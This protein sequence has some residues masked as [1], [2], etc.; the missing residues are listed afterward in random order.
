MTLTTTTTHSVPVAPTTGA[1]RPLGLDEVTHHRRVLGPAP[2]GER[3]ARPSRTSAD[4]SSAR[5]GSATSTSRHPDACPRGAAGASSRTPRSTSTSRPMAWEIGRRGGA[6]E[7]TDE[8]E[9]RFH[10]VVARVAAA[11]EPDGYL[12]TQFGRPGQQPRWS[13]LEWGHELYCLG[14]LFQATVARVRTRPDAD[15]GLV[16]V[17][18]RAADLVCEVFGEG[19]IERICGH[20]EVE[21]GLAELGRAL[22]RAALPG[23]GATLRRAPRPRHAARHRVGSLVLPGRRRRARRRRAAR[24]RRARELPLGGC[25]R[26]RRRDGRRGAAAGARPPVG[27]DRRAP[28][29]RD[30]RA[31]VAPPGRGVR[32]GLGAA[33]GPRLLRDLCR[34][35]IRDVQLAAAARAGRSALRR[36]DRAHPLQRDRD[37]AERR[38][39]RVLLREHA[40]PASP[41]R[42]G[43][44]RHGVAAGAVLA[45]RALVR[46][47]VL[48]A[49]H[50]AHVREP[51]GVP[52][53]GGCRGHPAAPVRARV[54]P[55]DARRRAGRR[56]RHR[57]G[58]P[59]VGC[60][61]GSRAH[62]CRG[63]VDP[64]AARPGVGGGRAA[65]PA[66]R[67]GRRRR[68]GRSPR[69][70]A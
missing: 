28:H 39:H 38:R 36:P 50:G 59:A 9:A 68:A 21:V 58:L 18:R 1:L 52:R 31:G 35:G 54:D 12:N 14:H 70:R 64:L 10:A 13:D 53:D 46:R 37:V 63:A 15:D 60:G 16:D 41:G 34:R 57:H 32:R 44:R 3:R 67:G 30:R 20:A 40:A 69:S 23:A 6:G 56:A 43:R 17:A 48:P 26:R 8:L 24:P 4:G 22:G 33:V 29:L 42:R 49:E 65:R 66:A 61:A 27:R 25:G 62:G 19:G 45:A 2:G 51:R 47:V 5:A 7:P 11:Q 55:H